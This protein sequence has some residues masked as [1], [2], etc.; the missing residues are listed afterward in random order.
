MTRKPDLKIV[1]PSPS[2]ATNPPRKLGKH[3]RTLW[4]VIMSEYD[5]TDTGGIEILQQICSTLDRAEQLSAEVER[6]G[7]TIVVKGQL[8][9]HPA[10]RAELGCRSFITRNLQ[11]L[12]LNLEAIRPTMGRPSKGLGVTS[13]E[14]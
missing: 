13:I 2:T 12:G 5:V 4:D 14:D 3:G 1:K 9:E 11:R 10:L 8:R 6:D 7:C